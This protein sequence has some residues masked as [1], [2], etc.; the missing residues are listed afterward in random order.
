[1]LPFDDIHWRPGSAM[2]IDD[3]ADIGRVLHSA[4]KERGWTQQQLAD[5]AGVSRDWVVR[6]E[7]GSG[8]VEVQLVLRALSA[9]G[10]AMSVGASR[11]PI[12]L[13]AI[14]ERHRGGESVA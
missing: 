11:S 5:S 3:A 4:R 1:M 8:R 9:L 12:D 10:M 13:A 14:V 2:R 7:Q 6:V